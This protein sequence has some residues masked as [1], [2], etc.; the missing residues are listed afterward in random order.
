MKVSF[1][2]LFNHL[3]GMGLN[4]I[5]RAINFLFPLS[6]GLPCYDISAIEYYNGLCGIM[7]SI[8]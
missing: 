7:V 8:L 5:M 3:S 1:L 2:H 6:P 4:V